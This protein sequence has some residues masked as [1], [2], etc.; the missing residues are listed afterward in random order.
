M[1]VIA[2]L[3]LLA[4]AGEERGGA[5]AD[6]DLSGQFEIDGSSTVQPITL[7]VAEEFDKIHPGVQVSIGVSGTGGGFKRFI[8]GETAVN[9]ASRPIKESEAERAAENGVE[10]VEFRVALDG[11]S[12]VVNPRNEFVECLT[13]DELRHVWQPASGIRRWS[14]VRP[15][16][17]DKPLR[18]YGPGT[19]SG[20]F[21]F[22]TEAVIGKSGA[23]RPDY[24]ASE[25]DNVLVQGV[26][27]DP[28]SLGYFGFAFYEENQRI[29]KL[30]GVDSGEGCVTPSQSTINGGEYHPLSRP[31]FI[32]VNTAFIDQP[33]VLEF[34]IFYME[35]ASEL[36]TEVGYV[37]LSDSAYQANLKRLE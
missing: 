27:G 11:L 19:N 20:T 33:E 28:N 10:Y 34:L 8:Q 30:I 2:G 6:S 18:L 32:Y 24:T 22:F 35:K 16:W 25:D 4:R 29:L 36:V 17:P 1:V 3:I 26:F 5:G 21:D 37:P 31:L 14:D 15:E 13:T 12:I 23:S 7:A 9:N